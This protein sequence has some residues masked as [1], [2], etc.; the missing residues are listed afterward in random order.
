MS[1]NF[2]LSCLLF[3]LDGT[4]LDTAPDL[5]G[6]L[7]TALQHRQLPRVSDA[8]IRPYISFGA[9][10][11]IEQSLNGD[12]D[13]ACVEPILEHMLEHYQQ[14]IA[15]RTRLFQGLADILD[16]LEAESIKW[17]VVTN[18]RKRFTE[19]LMQA[20]DL[21]PRAACIISGDST[22]NSKPHPE[23]MYAACAQANVEPQQCLYIG[24]SAHDISAGN[25]AGMKTLA[26]T[27]GYLK[28][29]DQP[30]LWGAA[31]LIEQPMQLQHWLSK[32]H[33]L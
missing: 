9:R 6:A 29:D 10:V 23:P 3:D 22:G 7:N 11:M 32:H 17:G 21:T 25:S 33:L 20:L 4:L 13:G 8:N 12:A 26:A 19:P 1:D 28:P 2:Q 31:G 27:Y 14:N 18:K 16:K 15:E 24:D 5:I 30:E